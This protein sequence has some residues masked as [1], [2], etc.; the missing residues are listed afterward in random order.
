MVPDA[1]RVTF[2]CKALFFPPPRNWK[3]S[4][5][6]GAHFVF[7]RHPY[8][9]SASGPVVLPAHEVKVSPCPLFCL[10]VCGHGD[11]V[12]DV[13]SC[14]GFLVTLFPPRVCCCIFLSLLLSSL[15]PLKIV[16]SYPPTNIFIALLAPLEV[17]RVGIRFFLEEVNS[18]SLKFFF[19]K[20]V[21]PSCRLQMTRDC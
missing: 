18:W 9:L 17:F 11:E 8:V 15:P 19:P 3:S 5:N 21:S 4:A 2:T 12:R 13:L 6:M 7:P 1:G 14:S 20:C 10:C 16:R